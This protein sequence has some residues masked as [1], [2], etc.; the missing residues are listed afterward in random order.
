M[1]TSALIPTL[2]HCQIL[3]YLSLSC[4]TYL[5]PSLGSWVGDEYL[6]FYVISSRF[7]FQALHICSVCVRI[8][9]QA[10]NASGNPLCRT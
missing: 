2:R 5:L 4:A 9:I 10:K 7:T 8:S 6:G 3:R 1:C